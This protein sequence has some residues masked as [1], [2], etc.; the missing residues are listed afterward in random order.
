M[1]CQALTRKPQ[2]PAAGS[3]IRSP[4]RG[5]RMLT[6][7]RMMWRGVRNWPFWPAVLSLPSRYSYKVALHVLILRRDLHGVDGLASLD[8]EAG[9]VD[10]E[11]G[12]FH[13]AREGAARA[14]ERLDEGKDGLL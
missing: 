9:L 13:L 1:C 11:L 7:M 3:Q 4:G 5:S 6:I 14:A 10:L 8:E 12:V 2:V